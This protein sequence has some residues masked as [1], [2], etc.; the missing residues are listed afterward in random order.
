M[1][2]SHKQYFQLW[3]FSKQTVYLAIYYLV[4]S[5]SANRSPRLYAGTRFEV[6]KKIYEK[7][8]GYCSI[9]VTIAVSV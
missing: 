1:F 9:F 6:M 4:V 8:N 7:K 2:F 3:L 5:V